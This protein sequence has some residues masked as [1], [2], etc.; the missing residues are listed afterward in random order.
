MS[1]T[2]GKP[3]Q[4]R[5]KKPASTTQGKTPLPGALRAR[6]AKNLRE[7]KA[8]KG[9]HSDAALAEAIGVSRQSVQGWM[10]SSKEY[11]TGIGV[12]AVATI[13][14]RLGVNLNWLLLGQGLPLANVTREPAE[15]ADDLRAQVISAILA[16][17][18]P[19]RNPARREFTALVE[20]VVP[21]GAT[22]LSEVAAVFETR[23]AALLDTAKAAHRA[24]WAEIVKV[25]ED[26]LSAAIKRGD[27]AK[28]A[29]HNDVR[30]S[31]A[32]LS[33]EA[34][35]RRLLAAPPV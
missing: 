6:V 14:E 21:T 31:A 18:A 20:A 3:S 32:E 34:A 9:L 19:D 23:V 5:A 35:V 25:E 8:L 33:D 22:L 7:I 12:P 4:S 24:R 15:L 17:G 13:A 30:R 29:W 16:R 26:K 28:I 2:K 10:T 27:Q 11:R 1:P